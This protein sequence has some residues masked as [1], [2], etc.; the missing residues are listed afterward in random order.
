MSRFVFFFSSH[1]RID[2]VGVTMLLLV[3]LSD[4]RSISPMPRCESLFCVLMFIFLFVLN[5]VRVRVSTHS[6]FVKHFIRRISFEQIEQVKRRK[7]VPC[8]RQVDLYIGRLCVWKESERANERRGNSKSR[9][10]INSNKWDKRRVEK[11]KCCFV[12]ADVVN[13]K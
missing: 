9:D 8:T 13:G 6:F 4:L 1:P 7:S 3:L 2:S 10:S 5:R 11:K 12:V